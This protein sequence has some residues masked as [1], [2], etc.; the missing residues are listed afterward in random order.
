MLQ[1]DLIVKTLISCQI[2][3]VRAEEWAG[4][5]SHCRL[6]NHFST[7]V[8][9]AGEITTS[10]AYQLISLSCTDPFH[11]Q[12]TLQ[13]R[14]NDTEL[15]VLTRLRSLLKEHYVILGEKF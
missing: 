12:S 8:T 14:E 7:N 2:N 10:A 6:H 13:G 5:R 1:I 4:Y 11:W 9:P 3:K 15:S